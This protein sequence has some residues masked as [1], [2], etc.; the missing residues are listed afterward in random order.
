MNY[1]MWR[2]A[3][4]SG[5]PAWTAVA[6]YWAIRFTVNN[7][8]R[9]YYVFTA[10]PAVYGSVGR[11]WRD[12]KDRLGSCDLVCCC[13]MWWRAENISCLSCL[14]IT[15]LE[16][17]RFFVLRYL[18]PKTLIGSL[19]A[20]TYRKFCPQCLVSSFPTY[21][22]QWGKENLVFPPAW[23]CIFYH[24]LAKVLDWVF[25]WG[26]LLSVCADYLVVSE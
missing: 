20:C 22:P 3:V 4:C 1:G 21:K 5:G 13:E 9:M 25:L 12:E 15:F 2:R 26:L 24:N 14:R 17:L 8:K 18:G 10:V 7:R 6:W 11:S 23:W 19:T 16:C